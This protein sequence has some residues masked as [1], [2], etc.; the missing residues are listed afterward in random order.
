MKNFFIVLFIL[1][2]TNTASFSSNYEKKLAGLYLHKTNMSIIDLYGSPNEIIIK[3]IENKLNIEITDFGKVISTPSHI[4]SLIWIYNFQNFTLEID[5]GSNSN[6]QTITLNGNKSPFKTDKGIMLGSTY[7]NVVAKYGNPNYS[8][9]YKNVILMNYSKSNI[10]FKIEKSK[11]KL[12]EHWV[13]KSISISTE[14]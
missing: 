6:I 12:Q 1:F 2:I 8:V 10:S 14:E 7:S 11:F 4:D 3:N 9:E 13:V 5:L